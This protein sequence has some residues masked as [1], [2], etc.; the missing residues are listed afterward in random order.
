MNCHR[1]LRKQTADLE[2]LTE[3]V[4]QDRP[5][6]WIKVHNLPDFVAFD[7]S[8]H[9]LSGVDCGACHGR[10]DTMVRVQQVAPLSMGWCLDCHRR[11]AADASKAARTEARAPAPGLDCGNCHY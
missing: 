10:V 3:A 2:R 1:L 7:H 5:I 9:V 11:R 4:E 6:A 8:R